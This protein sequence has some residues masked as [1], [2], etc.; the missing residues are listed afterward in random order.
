MLIHTGWTP[1]FDLWSHTFFL[2]VCVRVFTWFFFIYIYI[3][4]PGF[5]GSSAVE[6]PPAVQKVQEMR[7]QSLGGEDPL[8][9][10]MVTH[11]S[12]LAWRILRT[13]EPGRLQSTGSQ[14]VRHD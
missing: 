8:E 4:S 13:E 5:P 12:I 2:H 6:N 3:S 11:S 9:E 1:L 14:R 7:V 10:G